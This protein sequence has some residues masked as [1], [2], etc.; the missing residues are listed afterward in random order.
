MGAGG[1]CAHTQFLV[2]KSNFSDGLLEALQQL[3]LSWKMQEGCGIL[4]AGL[5]LVISSGFVVLFL[6]WALLLGGCRT[7]WVVFQG[8][9]P[10]FDTLLALKFYK[11]LSDKVNKP[12]EISGCPIIEL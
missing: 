8:T 7:G 12:E 10:E 11:S 9:S 2:T 1:A 4:S 5:L 6:T 3:S